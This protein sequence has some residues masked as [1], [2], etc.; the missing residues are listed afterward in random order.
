MSYDFHLK[1]IISGASSFLQDIILNSHFPSPRP[2]AEPHSMF[3][4][5]LSKLH[6]IPSTP[7]CPSPFLISTL[8]GCLRCLGHCVQ[9]VAITLWGNWEMRTENTAG[10][11]L[12]PPVCLLCDLWQVMQHPRASQCCCKLEVMVFTPTGL[13]GGLSEQG[14]LLSMWGLIAIVQLALQLFL[15]LP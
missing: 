3:T 11:G 4:S 6:L 12:L 5:W 9:L 14:S 1:N 2:S 7:L 10:G 15:A 13:Y 8:S